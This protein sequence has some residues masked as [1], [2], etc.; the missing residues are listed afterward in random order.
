ML[1][2]TR[3]TVRVPMLHKPT[4]P[5]TPN[6]SSG[7]GLGDLSFDLSASVPV[8]GNPSMECDGEALP[9][10]STICKS[11]TSR[12]AFRRASCTARRGSCAGADMQALICIA[13]SLRYAWEVMNRSDMRTMPTAATCLLSVLS[14]RHTIVHPCVGDG[15]ELACEALPPR[16]ALFC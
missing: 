7:P 14:T 8:L 9:C 13:E 10:V 16:P 6:A 12:L 5:V 15:F 4:Q 2:A 3:K 1:R 11:L